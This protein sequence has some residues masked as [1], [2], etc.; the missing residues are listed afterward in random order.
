MSVRVRFAPSP[1][2]HLHVGG[3]RTALFNWLY[4]K[5]HGGTFIVRV[6]DT[7]QARS[8]RESEKMVLDDLR[9]LGLNWDEGP[10]V[11]GPHEP[12]RQSERMELYATTASALLESGHAYRCFCSEED[13]DRKRELAEK[14]SQP[15]HYDLTCHRLTRAES[16][17]RNSEGQAS[18]IRFHV[19]KESDADFDG[20]VTI[21]DLIRG[22]ITWR[23]ESLGDFIVL[24]S[25]GMPTYNFSVVVD[26]HDMEI[27]HVIR[28]EEHLTNTHRQVLIYKAMNWSV[29]QFA[30]VSLILGSD[31]TKLSKRHGAT[32]VG[33]YDEKGFL[34]EAMLNYLTLLGWSSPDGEE[35]FDARTSAT[36]FTLERVN[37]APAVFDIQK[38]EW[39]NGQYIQSADP[40]RLTNR[41]SKFLL[42]RGWVTDPSLAEN[43]IGEGL[44]I[45]K[46]GMHTT[47]D[48]AAA[49]RFVFEFDA[50]S[51][52]SEA[53][54]VEMMSDPDARKVLAALET[55]LS[56]AVP[57]DPAEYKAL[58]EAVKQA[59]GVKGKKLFMPI[60]I[61]LTGTPHGP[62]LQRVVP[63]LHHATRTSGLA[64][65][66]GPLE[67]V[68]AT[69][70]TLG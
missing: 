70:A 68:R 32:S 57:D 25:D 17:T 56:K 46:T 40:R 49:L 58:A 6:E 13:L 27:S 64:P 61:A 19:P 50:G 33:A 45:V 23:K 29:P 54:A 44:D 39:M 12:Y 63:L 67:R 52:K 26:D 16:E 18:A 10:D 15:P 36:K 43:W 60:R 7:D 20:D 1:T 51:W 2:G 3:A 37:S 38:L 59:T 4:A 28:A 53:E 24:R 5:G 8:T 41:A 69:I 21:N 48:V 55:E 34:P 35:I 65:V 31:R 9:W 11:G 22:E 14:D 62:E 66:A 47:A 30:H 42:E